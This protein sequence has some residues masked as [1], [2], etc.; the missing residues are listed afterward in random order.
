MSHA[1]GLALEPE[2]DMG[3]SEALDRPGLVVTIQ[4]VTYPNVF[5]RLDARGVTSFNAAG[6]GKVT[7]QFGAGE[8]EKF[9][10]RP[11]GGN[12]YNIESFQFPN[13]YLRMDGGT[14]TSH[15]GP[16][17]GIVNGQFGAM[18]YER[19]AE[20]QP[21][22]QAGLTGQGPGLTCQA[23]GLAFQAGPRPP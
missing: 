8:Y 16:G 5:L 9:I 4:S 3:K 20:G 15:Q 21:A 11:C 17:S 1:M 22:C 12:E 23:R 14:V 18:T 2:A 6:V 13:V 10:L 7:C 19:V